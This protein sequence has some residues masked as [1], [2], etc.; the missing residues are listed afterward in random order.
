[1]RFFAAG[2][3]VQEQSTA[4]PR[5]PLQSHLTGMN[6][7]VVAGISPPP[8]WTALRD[9]YAA[10]IDLGNPS[11]DRLTNAIISGVGDVV[12]LRNMALVEEIARGGD[13]AAVGER[14]R[15]G[16]LTELLSL[17]EPVAQRNY[18]AAG[19]SY[20]DAGKRFADLAKQINVEGGTDAIIHAPRGGRDAWFSAPEVAG[21]VD[22][23]LQVLLAAAALAGAGDAVTFATA[24]TDVA[25]TEYQIA[26]AADPGN[27]HRRRV[28]EAWFTTGGRTGRWAALA[29]LGVKIRAASDPTRFTPYK[30]PE[31]L[32]PIT[33]HGGVAGF[34][35]RH[36]GDLP[37][38][39]HPAS[40][41][42]L[43]ETP[44]VHGVV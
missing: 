8:A 33:K 7:L 18:R 42:W 1:M 44:N 5:D 3:P 28:W 13:D 21:E 20:D 37:P 43:A 22:S 24:S 17:Y 16:V 23:A 15:A 19:A 25:T 34:W 11:A 41:G 38:G 39:W 14:V 4:Y 2:A 40:V 32:V 12:T 9:R 35:D 27:A 6:M 10:Y 30:R 29:A 31:E 36:D 26:L